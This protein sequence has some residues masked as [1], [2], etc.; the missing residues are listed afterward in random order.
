M[1]L[2]LEAITEQET[3]GVLTWILQSALQNANDAFVTQKN[4]T[5][6]AVAS[7][8]LLDASTGNEIG[9]YVFTIYTNLEK[10][11]NEILDLDIVLNNETPAKLHFECKLPQSS[12]SNEY[13]EILTSETKQ[14]LVVETVNRYTEPNEIEGKDKDVFVSAFPFQFNIFETVEAYNKSCGF[15]KPIQVANTDIKVHGLGTTFACPGNVLRPSDEET[16]WSFMA[17]EIKAFREIT[18]AFGSIKRAAYLVTLRSA[19]GDLPTIVGKEVF[20]TSKIGVG[21]IVS[22][23]AC[24]K[25]NFIKDQYPKAK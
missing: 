14:R 24:V 2:H 8:P 22:M 1:P 11:C 18:V 17:G 16:P 7:Y 23:Y 10:Q 6:Y 15:E 9:K 3:A 12:A 5:T 21:R 25:A 13:Y 20:D 4:G 19:L